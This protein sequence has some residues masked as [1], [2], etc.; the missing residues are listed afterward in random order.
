MNATQLQSFT[1]I[2]IGRV[3][4]TSA[5]ACNGRNSGEN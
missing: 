2:S 4:A 3:L 5:V 1:E